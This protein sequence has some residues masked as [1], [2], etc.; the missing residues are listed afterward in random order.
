[1]GNRLARLQGLE[2][3]RSNKFDQISAADR[4]V[5]DRL[6]RVL[7]CFLQ[8]IGIVNRYLSINFGGG[9]LIV[10]SKILRL[11]A[12]ARQA[13]VVSSIR[14]SYQ[15]ITH[16]CGLLLFRVLFVCLLDRVVDSFVLPGRLIRVVLFRGNCSG[17]SVQHVVKIEAY[18]GIVRRDSR[19]FVKGSLATSGNHASYR[20]K[21]SVVTRVLLRVA[22]FLGKHV[23]GTAR[24][25]Y[26]VRALHANQG[27]VRNGAATARR[28]RV[29]PRDVR[30][31]RRVFRRRFFKEQR[32]RRL[33]RGRPLKL[34]NATFRLLTMAIM[35]RASVNAVLISG[36]R[37]KLS[38]HRGVLSLMLMVLTQ[39]LRRLFPVHQRC[40]SVLVEAPRGRVTGVRG[41]ELE[42]R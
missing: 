30:V 11:R 22:P 3:G 38:R 41:F 16:R 23:G 15:A 26:Q 18:R 32:L 34:S 29:G 6:G 5:G 1:M 40:R 28:E 36:R 20:Y 33:Q 25:L 10:R 39:F 37:S 4:V 9:G 21:Y 7:A 42:Q 27:N 31:I 14:L 8:V 2:L 19:L 24:G 13:C 17:L 35:R 12:A